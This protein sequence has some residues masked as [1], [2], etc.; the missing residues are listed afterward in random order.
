MIDSFIADIDNDELRL[1][2][3]PDM[4]EQIDDVDG[5]LIIE[6][7]DVYTGERDNIPSDVESLDLND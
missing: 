3:A 5:L 7:E 6:D 2:I 1:H 4:D